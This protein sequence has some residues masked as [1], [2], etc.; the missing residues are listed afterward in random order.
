MLT[1]WQDCH[2]QAGCAANDIV[3]SRSPGRK[4]WSLPVRIYFGPEHRDADDRRRAG[5]GQACDLAYYVIQ[6]EDKIRPQS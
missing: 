3:I 5:L 1:A 4:T 6:Q 2:F